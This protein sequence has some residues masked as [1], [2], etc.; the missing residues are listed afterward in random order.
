MWRGISLANKTLLLFGAAIVLVVLTALA[1]P[2]W[3][4]YSLV[5]AGQLDVSRTMIAAWEK[6]AQDDAKPEENATKEPEALREHAGILARRLTVDQARKLAAGDAFLGWAADRLAAKAS[7]EDVQQASWDG[8][9]REYRYAKAVRDGAGA[10][11]TLVG[12]ISLERRSVPASQLLFVNSA[13]LLVAG[14]FVLAVA[15]AVF[16]FITHRL[17][18]SPVHALRETA[19]RA[20]RGDLEVRA[21]IATGDEFEELAETFNF[22]LTDL[23]ASQDQLRAVNAAMD[24]KLSELSEMNS[25]LAETARLKGEFLANVSHELRTPLNSIIGF[26]ELLGEFAKA[27]TLLAEPPQSAPKRMRYVENILNASRSLLDMIND[28]LE[29]AK[30]ESG[31]I[32]VNIQTMNLAEACEAA[33]GLIMPLA[34]KKGLPLKVELEDDLPIIETDPKKFQQILFNFLSNAVKFTPSPTQSGR[35]ESVT[36]RVERL[37]GFDPGADGKPGAPGKVRVSVIDTGPGIAKEDQ[38]K[39]FEKFRQLSQGHTREH[40][41][42]GLGL[43]ISRELAGIL[44]GEVQVVSE[45]GQ[46]SMFSLILPERVDRE[47]LE[48][49]RIENRFK[50]Q[51]AR[52]AWG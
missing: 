5:D 24:L 35:A 6:A 1:A 38:P 46:G 8:F 40:G 49:K 26:A 52:K 18:L 47:E 7:L 22:M 43:A 17:V 32:E 27:D 29:M 15:V 16:Y 50:T 23:A 2:W 3:R 21:E 13:Y 45:F 10:K 25:S 11:A 36:L 28:L 42:T 44:Q 12:L 48:S 20:R 41:G 37:K 9:A 14:F 30:I 39:L 4:M 51:A 33:A 31:K 19:E 34:D